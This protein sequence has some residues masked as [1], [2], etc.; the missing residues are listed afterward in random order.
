MAVI[1]PRR[2]ANREAAE[3]GPVPANPREHEIWVEDAPSNRVARGISRL[4][5]AA[6]TERGDGRVGQHHRAGSAPRRRAGMP[7]DASRGPTPW[8]TPERFDRAWCYAQPSFFCQPNEK[9]SQCGGA[10]SLLPL[11]SLGVC[12][13]CPGGCA[14]ADDAITP[15]GTTAAPNAMVTANSFFMCFLPVYRLPRGFR[16][17]VRPRNTAWEVIAIPRSR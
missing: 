4:E 7:I 3:L 2:R 15:N 16:V 10:S 12:L 13:H 5:P 17:V 9:S 14:P 6:L 8:P 11:Q 1:Q